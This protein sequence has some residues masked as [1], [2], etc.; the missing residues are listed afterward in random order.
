MFRWV[1]VPSPTHVSKSQHG[2]KVPILEPQAT[3][4]IW[5]I[6]I[7]VG[8]WLIYA[9]YLWDCCIER[10]I[11]LFAWLNSQRKSQVSSPKNVAIYCWGYLNQHLLLLLLLFTTLLHMLTFWLNFNNGFTTP[12]YRA[13]YASL[14][15]GSLAFIA[16]CNFFP[17]LVH[18][19]HGRITPCFLQIPQP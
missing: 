9:K 10:W 14:H 3:T 1:P 15:R 13:Q 17:T 2:G 8:S 12:Q 6:I 16:C 11:W 19:L 4:K 7:K 5:L 18:P